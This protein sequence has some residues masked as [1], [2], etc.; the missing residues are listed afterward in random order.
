MELKPRGNVCKGLLRLYR[1]DPQNGFKS[2]IQIPITAQYVGPHQNS[3]LWEQSH[4]DNFV[5]TQYP[6]SR[7]KITVPVEKLEKYPNLNEILSGS[8]KCSCEGEN[9]S[10]YEDKSY[11][12]FVVDIYDDYNSE[13][14]YNM[15]IVLANSIDAN[16]MIL[17]DFT[18]F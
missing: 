6:L 9:N 11:Y 12:P 2:P 10:V 1:D 7:I 16:G 18:G 3:G 14:F 17:T 15:D 8:H 13:T 4:I 5:I